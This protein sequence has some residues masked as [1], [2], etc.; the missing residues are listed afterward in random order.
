MN[1][2]KPDLTPH[3]RRV[4]YFLREWSS[5]IDSLIAATRHIRGGVERQHRRRQRRN[6]GDQRPA[7]RSAAELR[8]VVRPSGPRSST[9]ID[10]SLHPSTQSAICSDLGGVMAAS[11]ARRGEKFS[12]LIPL[13]LI[14]PQPRQSREAEERLSGGDSISRR[15]AR[16][17]CDPPWPSLAAAGRRPSDVHCASIH[18]SD[19]VNLTDTSTKEMCRGF[20]STVPW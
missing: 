11:L 10:G 13:P 18:L 16:R 15:T 2:L 3:Q 1:P 20:P 4:G 12:G 8:V 7:A 6:D 19:P 5:E 9:R 17:S 14:A